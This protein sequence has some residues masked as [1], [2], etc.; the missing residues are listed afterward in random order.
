MSEVTRPSTPPDRQLRLLANFAPAAAV[1]FGLVTVWLAVTTVQNL[2]WPI[3]PAVLAS[4]VLGTGLAA[5][6]GVV[7]YRLA[8]E[9]PR[10]LRG[11]QGALDE[12]VRVLRDC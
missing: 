10:T 7:T 4:V 12:R 3:T 5:L 6:A 11:W 1:M 2:A 8:V 9:V